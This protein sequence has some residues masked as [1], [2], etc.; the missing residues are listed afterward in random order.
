[1]A[2]SATESESACRRARAIPLRPRR[3]PDRHGLQWFHQGPTARCGQ[4]HASF[5]ERHWRC[6]LPIAMLW[7]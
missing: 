5:G 1:M 7:N 4:H 2:H 6:S 3:R